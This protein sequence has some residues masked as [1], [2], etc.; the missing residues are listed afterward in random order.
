[1]MLLSLNPGGEQKS[2]QKD[3]KL[4]LCIPVSIRSKWHNQNIND[5]GHFN[6]EFSSRITAKHIRQYFLV[7]KLD[8][9]VQ[10]K[11]QLFNREGFCPGYNRL[12][13]NHAVTLPVLNWFWLNPEVPVIVPSLIASFSF[14]TLSFSSPFHAL[15]SVNPCI[16]YDLEILINPLEVGNCHFHGISV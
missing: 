11:I 13:L 6:V 10:Y 7:I 4:F 16:S 1:M 3:S 2:A 14:P 8:H 12:D 5:D 9:F 15:D